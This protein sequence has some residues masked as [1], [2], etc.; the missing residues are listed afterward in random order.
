MASHWLKVGT[1]RT[2]G[3][4]A[5]ESGLQRQEVGHTGAVRH[6]RVSQSYLT[7]PHP[8]FIHI[9]CLATAA[10]ERPGLGL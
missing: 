10:S 4:A 2:Q 6:M 8:Q 9:S 5:I 7:I 1:S 3:S